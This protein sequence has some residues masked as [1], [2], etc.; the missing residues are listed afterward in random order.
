MSSLE[1][2]SLN[3][4][5]A[6]IGIKVCRIKKWENEPRYFEASFNQA[7]DLLMS[8]IELNKNNNGGALKELIRLKALLIDA[9][10]GGRE[11]NAKLNDF[12]KYF[13][14]FINQIKIKR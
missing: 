13:D 9:Y 2:I 6:N 12:L 8:V 7:F 10:V 11:F 5:L 4:Q 14:Y 1:K 3:E